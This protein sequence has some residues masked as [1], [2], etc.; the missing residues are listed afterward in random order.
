M[1]TDITRFEA[2][3]RHPFDTQCRNGHFAC[4]SLGNRLVIIIQKLDD[5]KF[6]LQMSA[7]EFAAF[8]EG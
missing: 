8:G 2:E 7:V 4:F 1:V 5:D 6:R 3:Q